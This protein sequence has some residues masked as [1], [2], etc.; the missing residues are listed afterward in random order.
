MLSIRM[1]PGKRPPLA[2]CCTLRTDTAN[3]SAT[4]VARMRSL[5]APPTARRAAAR[6]GAAQSA[7]PRPVAPSNNPGPLCATVLI[8]EL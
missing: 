2:N 6:T 3:I 1:A 4:A 5:I 8:D 7:S